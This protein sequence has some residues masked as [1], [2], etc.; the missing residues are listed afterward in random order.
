V[1]VK[2]VTMIA[3]KTKGDIETADRPVGDL[4]EV[5]E[6][7]GMEVGIAAA[8][9]EVEGVADLLVRGIGKDL[10]HVDGDLQALVIVIQE[11]G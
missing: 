10:H 8:E 7:G 11:S 6:G 2:I 4:P 1:N 3:S 9:V 5:E